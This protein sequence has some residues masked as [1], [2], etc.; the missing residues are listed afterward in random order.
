ML[1]AAGVP[2][3]EGVAVFAVGFPGV[4]GVYGVTT[5]FVLSAS[6]RL[7]VMGVTACPIAAQMIELQTY[8][9]GPDK[10]LIGQSMGPPSA[11]AHSGHA[12]PAVIL[13]E[14]PVPTHGARINI[15]AL[16]NTQ[17]QRV[18]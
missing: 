2:F 13:R 18:I 15:Y 9:N 16:K 5:Q 14:S 4:G 1:V 10:N 7:K 11:A 3:D 8:W 17:S 6:D 12:V